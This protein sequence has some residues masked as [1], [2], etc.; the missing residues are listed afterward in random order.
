MATD[1]QRLWKG[2]TD[3]ADEDEAVHTLVKIVLDK[4]GRAFLSNFGRADATLCIEILDN[5]SLDKHL[6]RPGPSR[7]APSGHRSIRPQTRRKMRLL[8]CIKE[9]RWNSRTAPRI[10]GPRPKR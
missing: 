8:P 9:T 7:T 4:E 6:L 3:A 2:V 10:R 5:V 1:Y